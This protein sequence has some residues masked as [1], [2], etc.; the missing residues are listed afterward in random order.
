LLGDSARA[1]VIVEGFVVMSSALG[2]MVIFVPLNEGFRSSAWLKILKEI[3][4]IPGI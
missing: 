3:L 1:T 2:G 4:L